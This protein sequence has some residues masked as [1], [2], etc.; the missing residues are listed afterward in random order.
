[1]HP[2]W[3]L[4]VAFGIP[5]EAAHTALGATLGATR[6]ADSLRQVANT[7]TSPTGERSRV[8]RSRAVENDASTPTGRTRAYEPETL[9]AEVG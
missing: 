2:S 8:A 4:E 6:G 7:V 9:A 1:M 5:D 3:T